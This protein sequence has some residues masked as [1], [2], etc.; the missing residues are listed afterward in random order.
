MR[1]IP[2]SECLF[3]PQVD[4]VR[5][6]HTRGCAGQCRGQA[7]TGG[8]AHPWW[9]FSVAPDLPHGCSCCLWMSKEGKPALVLTKAEL[10][11]S[12]ER[13]SLVF[14]EESQT[15]LR[16]AMDGSCEKEAYSEH[17]H[18]WAELVA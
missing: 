9:L 18:S 16:L 1:K 4:G 13:S 7:E 14:C 11:F 3:F 5:A 15:G 17:H 8:D 6:S 2:E 12:V 10:F